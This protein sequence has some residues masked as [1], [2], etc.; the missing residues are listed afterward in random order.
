MGVRKTNVELTG[1]QHLGDP[2]NVLL[3]FHKSSLWDFCVLPSGEQP[4]KTM[5]RSTI[6]H[7][8]IHYFDW[9]IFHCFLYV[10][11]RVIHDTNTPGWFGPPQETVRIK[12]QIKSIDDGW[13]TPLKNMKVRLD[14][15]PNYWG[16][17]QMFQTTNQKIACAICILLRDINSDKTW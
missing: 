14:H 8:K 10:H 1:G 5:E 11:Q 13:P 3:M 7:G 12:F 6:F 16:K 15:H 9:A 17:Y 2:K 4:Q